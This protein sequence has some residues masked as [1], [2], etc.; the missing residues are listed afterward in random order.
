MRDRREMSVFF[1]ERERERE[2]ERS[3]LSFERM[4]MRYTLG[5]YIRSPRETE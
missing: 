5:K 3:K 1:R 4:L 2:R